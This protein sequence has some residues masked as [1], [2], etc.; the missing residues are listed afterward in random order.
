MG[1]YHRGVKLLM[2]Q[3]FL[4]C[5]DVLPLFNEMRGKTVPAGI[6]GLSYLQVLMVPDLIGFCQ[7]KFHT[8]LTIDLNSS[9][10][11]VIGA[12]S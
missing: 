2:A 7:L 10:H 8:N 4:N 5:P 9:I 3:E 11:E 12:I 1:V 6:M